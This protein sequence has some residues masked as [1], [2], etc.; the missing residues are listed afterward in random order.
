MRMGFGFR[1]DFKFEPLFVL[2]GW[3]LDSS[4]F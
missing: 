3:Y 4:R 1:E 2:E